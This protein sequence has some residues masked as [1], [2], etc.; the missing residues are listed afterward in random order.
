MLIVIAVIAQGMN[1]A[2]GIKLHSLYVKP[3]TAYY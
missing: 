1:I 3:L 2:I